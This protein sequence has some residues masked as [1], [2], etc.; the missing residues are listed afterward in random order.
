M[1]LREFHILFLTLAVL[2]TGGF[3]AWTYYMPELAKETNA[4]AVGNFSGS[5]CIALVVYTLWFVFV[6]GKLNRA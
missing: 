3:W 2:C 6:K 4:L 1:S 5:L